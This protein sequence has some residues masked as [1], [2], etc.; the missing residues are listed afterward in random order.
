MLGRSPRDL[1]AH[2]AC[3]PNQSCHIWGIGALGWGRGHGVCASPSTL[4]IVL[5][6]PPR[7][8]HVRLPKYRAKAIRPGRCGLGQGG[9][10]LG[11]H[12][13]MHTV[14]KPSRLGGGGLGDGGLG[15]AAW[16][17][18]PKGAILALLPFGSAVRPALYAR[19]GPEGATRS[20]RD[21]GQQD[22]HRAKATCHGLGVGALG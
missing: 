7:A 9:M 5:G 3:T 13:V 18:C 16:E 10:G 15:M 6:T 22:A 12:G 8:V 1:H 11:A 14:P 19:R 4:G 17:C 2:T 20:E 21:K